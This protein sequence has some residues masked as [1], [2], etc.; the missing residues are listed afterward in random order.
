[1]REG[2]WCNGKRFE[3]VF[4]HEFVTS[5]F[6]K[7][8]KNC[9]LCSGGY[10]E[11]GWPFPLPLSLRV[12]DFPTVLLAAVISCHVLQSGTVPCEHV[13]RLRLLIVTTV[14]VVVSG[15]KTC[16]CC[17]SPATGVVRLRQTCRP[18]FEWIW[19]FI[20]LCRNMFYCSDVCDTPQL[21]VS[22]RIYFAF[23]LNV[24]CLYLISL[25]YS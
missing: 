16:V 8:K 10:W 12:V 22:I 14:P 18:I 13:T 2:G 7:L 9:P 17:T 11:S 21:A 23:N 24:N 4:L 3:K 25:R 19:I 1:M 6:L 5:F 15:P 20:Y